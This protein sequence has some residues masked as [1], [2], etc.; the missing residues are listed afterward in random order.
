MTVRRGFTLIE[1]LIAVV[2]ID[3]GL[4]AL[5]AG[6]TIIVAQT[7]ELRVRSAATR[8]AG[9][10]LQQL[11][12]APCVPATGSAVGPRDLQEHWEVL[13][14]GNETRQVN[15][16]VTFRAGGRPAWIVLRTRFPC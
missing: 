4:L 1:V 8:A 16:S 7:N 15:D 5:V 14:H 6:S 2:L 12:A 9:N 10:R 11:G 13:L 3:V